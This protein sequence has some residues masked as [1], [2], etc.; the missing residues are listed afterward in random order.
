MQLEISKENQ[1]SKKKKKNQL[2]TEDLEFSWF[3]LWKHFLQKYIFVSS[4]V[5]N[6]SELVIKKYFSN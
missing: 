4:D 3:V 5:L 6:S 1:V 2:K